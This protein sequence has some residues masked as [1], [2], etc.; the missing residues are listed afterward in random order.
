[1]NAHGVEI[2]RRVGRPILSS[3]HAVF[4]V[5]GMLG[6]VIAGFVVGS[7]ISVELHFGIAA[8]VIAAFGVLAWALLLPGRVDPPSSGPLFQ[9]PP[10]AVLG[11]GLL[12]FGSLM[13]EGSVADWSACRRRSSCTRRPCSPTRSTRSS[14]R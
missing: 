12:A 7:Q 13:A 3:F 14:M 11:L 1:M 8:L 4:S 5:G 9:R 2:E 10:R 6:A